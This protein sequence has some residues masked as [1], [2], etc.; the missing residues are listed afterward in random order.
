M[1]RHHFCIRKW[2]VALILPI[3][4][5]RLCSRYEAVDALYKATSSSGVA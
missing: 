1:C 2:F 5:F 4:L 3:E